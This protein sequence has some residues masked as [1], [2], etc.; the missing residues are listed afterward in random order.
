MG[1]KLLRLIFF[2]NYFVGLLAI[3]LT[4]ESTLQLGLP[5][6]SAAYYLLVFLAPIIYYT[7]AYMGV[8]SSA[9]TSN[10]RTLW[11]AGHIKQV[12]LTQQIL[13]IIC[14]IV[15]LYLGIHNIKGILALPVGYWIGAGLIGLVAILY[16][17]ML[18]LFSFNLNLRNTGLLKPFVIGLVW[19][20]TANFF[21]LVML[22]IET[23]TAIGGSSLW[24]FLFVKNWMFCTVNA[25]MFDMK[26]YAIDYNNQLKTF[27]VRIGLQRTVNQVLIPLLLTG[28]VSLVIF[29]GYRHFPAG[30]LLFNLLPFLLTIA[31][32]YSMNK[33]KQIFYYLIVIDGLI[34]L[35]ALCGITSM[36]LFK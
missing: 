5:F 7:Y 36:L 32:A 23:G 1:Q 16:Y 3:A 24:Y 22:K 4:V 31:V 33:R 15:A 19:A 34:L 20:A 27:V 9:D 25:I 13:L 11:Y 17:G 26:D 14:I 12:R 29:A 8:S 10:P 21:P 28:V 30:R 18:P 2:G 35:K 6:N